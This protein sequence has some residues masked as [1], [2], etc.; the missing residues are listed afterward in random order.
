MNGL[1]NNQSQ[2]DEKLIARAALGPMTAKEIAAIM[3]VDDATEAVRRLKYRK[4]I[5]IEKVGKVPGRTNSSY[6][7]HVEIGD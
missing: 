7:Y 5:N 1:K 3:G 4:R 6:L 2:Y